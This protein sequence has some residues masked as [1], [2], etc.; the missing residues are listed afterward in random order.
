MPFS[1]AIK[2]TFAT[3]TSSRRTFSVICKLM[4]SSYVTSVVQSSSSL[5]SQMFLTYV[6]DTTGLRSLSSVILTTQPIL[7]FGPSAVSS[8][9]SC[10]VSQ[11]S[12]VKAVLTNSSRSSKFWELHLKNKYKPWILITK[13]TGSHK[14]DLCHGRRCSDIAL[15]LRPLTSFQDYCNM[16]QKL[17]LLLFLVF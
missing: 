7:M 1:T 11:F 16:T 15:Q 3:E 9:N 12:Q 14:F 10:S 2:K 6:L 17:D 13:N 8:L 4:C 5:V